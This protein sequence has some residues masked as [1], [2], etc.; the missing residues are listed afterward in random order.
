MA[1]LWDLYDGNK[2]KI[3]KQQKEEFMNF[4]MEK[5]QILNG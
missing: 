1:E 2:K 5:Q 3:G 4:Q